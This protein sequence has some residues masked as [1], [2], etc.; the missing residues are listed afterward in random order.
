MGAVGWLW[1]CLSGFSYLQNSNQGCPKCSCH[2]GIVSVRVSDLRCHEWS[3]N[4]ADYQP[5]WWA[6][7]YSVVLDCSA[8]LWSLGR[9]GSTV[10]KLVSSPVTMGTGHCKLSQL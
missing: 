1:L 9:L 3:E 4:R 2:H 10:P 6:I 8:E 7:S 5:S